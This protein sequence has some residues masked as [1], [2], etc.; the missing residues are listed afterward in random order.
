MTDLT[1]AAGL[2]VARTRDGRLVIVR[3]S[4]LNGKT[5]YVPVRYVDAATLSRIA[6]PTRFRAAPGRTQPERARFSSPAIRQHQQRQRLKVA[7]RQR[8]ASGSLPMHRLILALNSASPALQVKV[9]SKNPELLRF[10]RAPSE[11][12]QMAA[13]SAKPSVI[14]H[15]K[16]PTEKVQLAAV[17]R[18]G[19]ALQFI[20]P[21][22]RTERV[23]MAAVRQNGLAV[24][25]IDSP[26]PAVV[27]AALS[28]NINARRYT[29]VKHANPHREK[30]NLER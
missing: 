22:N 17:T 1:L 29:S 28:Q 25:F 9:L 18:D 7:E 14:R 24:R 4:E 16:R 3:T 15:L 27:K 5:R 13:V 26:S 6:R 21:R 2:S 8:L 23:L 20:H 19:D 10:M 11:A 30:K 12:V